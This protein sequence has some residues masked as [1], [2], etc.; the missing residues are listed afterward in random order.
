MYLGKL[1]SNPINQY[2]KPTHH[3]YWWQCDKCHCLIWSSKKNKRNIPEHNCK[4]VWFKIKKKCGNC[5]ESDIINCIDNKCS[6][7][8]AWQPDYST[9]EL[10]NQILIDALK[11]IAYS[12]ECVENSQYGTGVVDGHR[13]CSNIALEALNKIKEVN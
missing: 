8:S 11:S 10:T 7:F 13:Y 1:L 2:T 12:N 3:Y 9:L 4:G 6:N 5:R